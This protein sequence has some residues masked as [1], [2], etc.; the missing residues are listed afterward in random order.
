MKL[1]SKQI[2]ECTGGSY[3]VEPIDASKLGCRVSWDSR[4]VLPNDVYVALPGDKVDG[5]TFV[6][7]ALKNGAAIVLVA[8]R[9]TE[10]TC[11]LAQEMGAALIEVPNTASALVD[12]AYAWRRKLK[13]RIIGITGSSG[14]TTTKNLIRDVLGASFSVVATEANQNNELGVPKTILTAEADTQV[15]VVE[16]GMRGKGQI[17]ELCAYVMP[18]M[19]V[20]TNVGDGHIELL[21]T[22][23]NIACAKA[24]LLRALPDRT[25]KAFIRYEEQFGVLMET[26]A[27][28][29]EREVETIYFGGP[30]VPCEVG[31]LSSQEAAEAQGGR[32]GAWASDVV[33]DAQGRPHFTLHIGAESCPC[34]VRLRGLHNVDNACAAASVASELGMDI[35]T[36]VAALGEAEPECGR[37]EVLHARDGFMV[38]NDAY[39]ANP[40]SMR[41]S[42]LMFSALDIPGRR[43]AVLGDMGELGDH[44]R[45]CHEDIGVLVASLKIDYLICIGE[46]SRHL[47][48]TACACGMDA[49]DVYFASS[50]GDILGVLEKSVEEGDAVLV[51]ASH[52]MGLERV[53][54]GLVN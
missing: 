14:K 26:F 40:D 25:G 48:D 20:I 30:E 51:K 10:E 1:N 49:D 52:F 19:G 29:E 39:N 47:L 7:E 42:L 8:D 37:Q 17:A 6:D 2:S 44:A 28:L 54:G 53:V 22:R 4:T 36:I 24:E 41:A 16:M 32:R 50:I 11:L 33:L 38:V 46:E 15:V 45:P 13:S 35:K 9:P 21:K 31:S 43:I 5:H 18:D 12:M 34:M 3:I 23:E 27:R